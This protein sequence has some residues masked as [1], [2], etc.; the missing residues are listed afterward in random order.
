[1]IHVVNA[2]LPTYTSIIESADPLE[3]GGTETIT[4]IGVTDFS[5]IHT[6]LIE[7]MG[8]IYNMSNLGGNTTHGKWTDWFYDSGTP[9]R[10]GTY[11]Y[12][13]YIQD[14]A[15]N[16]NT[17]NGTIQVQRTTSPP[18]FEP[19]LWLLAGI[20]AGNVIFTI[21]LYRRLNKKVQPLLSPKT[22]PPKDLPKKMES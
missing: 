11:P 7:F 21:A 9:D 12:I 10:T 2:T 15:G 4:I 17:I 19:F 3:L 14:N 22:I 1:M 5:G 6:V 18:A 16:W 8:G 13:I 20:I